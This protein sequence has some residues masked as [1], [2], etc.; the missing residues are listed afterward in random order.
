[1][2]IKIKEPRNL[3]SV[4]NM[5]EVKSIISSVYLRTDKESD[6]GT[7]AYF[8]K[9]RDIAVI[10]LLFISGVRVSELSHLSV[11]NIDL[12]TGQIKVKGKGDKERIVVLTND[13]V[14]HLMLYMRYYHVNSDSDCLSRS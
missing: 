8:A 13:T 9:I 4:M 5:H 11:S 10:E 3:P 2:R 1:M 6:P 14:G 12:I 7:Y